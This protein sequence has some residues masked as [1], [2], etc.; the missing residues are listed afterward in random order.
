[1]KEM[2]DALGQ[3]LRLRNAQEQYSIGLI[4][5]VSLPRMHCC[6]HVIVGLFCE[7][8]ST[9]AHA[10]LQIAELIMDAPHVFPME[11]ANGATA[12]SALPIA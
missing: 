9:I 1:V 3:T 11:T 5:A 4:L 10:Y 12:E 8:K 2:M 7:I 6:T